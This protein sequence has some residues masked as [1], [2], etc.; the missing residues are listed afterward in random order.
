MENVEV[1]VFTVHV[2]AHY[3]YMSVYE[4]ECIECVWVFSLPLCVCMCVYHLRAWCLQSQKSVG[5]L[6]LD[7]AVCDLPCGAVTALLLLF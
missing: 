4:Y 2:C 5:S 6:E 3:E 1:L 7:T